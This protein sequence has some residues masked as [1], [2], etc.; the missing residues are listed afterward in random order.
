MADKVTLAQVGTI[1][2]A[3]TAATTINNNSA[4]IVA[5]ID[6]TL[7]LDGTQPN[8]MQA[9]LDMNSYRILNLPAAISGSEPARLEDLATVVAGGTVTFNALPTGGTTGELLIKNSSSNY[10][11]SWGTLTP[12]S[13]I[14]VNTL[15]ANTIDNSGLIT[16]GSLTT[17]ALTATSV[18]TATGTVSGST[19]YTSN[20]ILSG[21]STEPIIVG[22]GAGSGDDAGILIARTFTSPTGLLNSHAVRDESVLGINVTAN[23]FS[24]YASY[25]S[26]CELEGQAL[27][28]QNHLRNFQARSVWAASGHCT[29]WVGLWVGATVDNAAGEIDNCYG[30][31]VTTP[32]MITG[33]IGNQ[34]AFYADPLSGGANNYFLY[35]QGAA[36]PSVL[37]GN[38]YVGGQISQVSVEVMNIRY[39]GTGQYGLLFTDQAGGSSGLTAISYYRNG[40]NVGTITTTNTA[41]AYNTSSDERLKDFT[42]NYDPAEA[43]RII[44]ADPV[45]SF[46]WKADGS[47]AIGWG[48]QTSY[49]ISSDLASKPNDEEKESWGVDQSKRTPYLWAAMSG[50]L[51]RLDTLEK[52]INGTET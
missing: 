43:V 45:R 41:T 23:Q 50:I 1:I 24:G 31:H 25:D 30:V 35:G 15:T 9:N 52:K 42:G 17:G 33:S 21:A 51:E 3:T 49:A 48:A 18:T 14:S 36:N 20:G 37:M 19:H 46:N 13:N 29:E 27:T 32:N 7:S 34:Y 40:S 12:S 26:F 4:A 5:A 39:T 6:N 8:Q 47:S 38:L 22:N 10:D 11:A 16:T 28:P 2:D 44:R